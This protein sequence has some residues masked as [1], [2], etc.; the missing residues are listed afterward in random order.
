MKFRFRMAAVRL[1]SQRLRISSRQRCMS[2]YYRYSTCNTSSTE[3]LVQDKS[4]QHSLKNQFECHTLSFINVNKKLPHQSC[5]FPKV[6]NILT[7][8]KSVCKLPQNDIRYSPLSRLNIKHRPRYALHQSQ[9]HTD[10][11]YSTR[12]D[13]VKDTL[14]DWTEKLEAADVPE[15]SLAVEYI[16]SHILDIPRMELHRYASLTLSEEMLTEIERLMTCRLARMP[17]Q[18]ILGEWD[19]HSITL[20]VRPPVFIPRPETEK[21]VELALECLQGIKAPRILEIGCGSGAICLSLLHILGD[22]HCVAVDQSKHAIEVTALNAASLRVTDRLTLVEGKVTSEKMPSL[23][24]ECF[25]LIISNP[26][27]MLRKDLLNVQPEIM[28]YEDM[29]ALDGG[30][31]GLDVIKAVIKHSQHLLPGGHALLLE[32]DPCHCYL[33]PTWMEKQPTLKLNMSKVFQDFN[34]KDRFIKFVKLS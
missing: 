5:F 2:S 16:I 18:Y 12:A 8:M 14:N 15:A 28:I 25:D 23:P 20:K 26:P 6:T 17:L 29:R 13:T 10:R 27:Y 32:V 4:S 11:S 33:I 3:I 24:Q 21:L 1:C 7:S 22:L 9:T 30:K 31:E 19:F 34:G